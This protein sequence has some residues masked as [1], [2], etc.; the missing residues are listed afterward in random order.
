MTASVLAED[1]LGDGDPLKSGSVESD[2]VDDAFEGGEVLVD[3]AVTASAGIT[4]CGYVRGKDPGW[5]D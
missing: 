1:V 5:T 4:A 2:L 3:R